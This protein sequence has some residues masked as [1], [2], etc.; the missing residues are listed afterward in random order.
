MW[1]PP[2]K[3]INMALA[4]TAT[5]NKEHIY[6]AHT[7]VK[8]MKMIFNI[9]EMN[10][11]VQIIEI[12]SILCNLLTFHIYSSFVRSFLSIFSS[13]FFGA[14]AS[15]YVGFC[16]CARTLLV[17]HPFILFLRL[18]F[19]VMFYHRCSLSVRLVTVYG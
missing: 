9:H 15:C 17:S 8:W 2:K 11:I 16:S 10:K 6:H 14:F 7:K 13:I 18:D 5:K 19:S 3:L 1:M 12:M 4:A